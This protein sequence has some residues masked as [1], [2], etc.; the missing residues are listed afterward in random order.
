[1]V[2]SES[3]LLGTGTYVARVMYAVLHDTPCILK[4]ENIYKGCVVGRWG[5]GLAGSFGGRDS[6]AALAAEERK[7]RSSIFTQQ[8]Y[9]AYIDPCGEALVSSTYLPPCKV[10]VYIPPVIRCRST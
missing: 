3:L 9:L 7:P 2:S 8:S 6:L 10:Y 1:M 4:I 5:E